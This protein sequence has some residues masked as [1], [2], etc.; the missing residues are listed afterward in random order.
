M[1]RCKLQRTA[2]KEGKESRFSLGLIMH[3]YT[4]L[5]I[6][7][8]ALPSCPYLASPI[9]SKYHNGMPNLVLNLGDLTKFSNM[10]GVDG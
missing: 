7:F 8:K 1:V 10:N 5:Y 9:L 6:D 4:L 3:M 2:T